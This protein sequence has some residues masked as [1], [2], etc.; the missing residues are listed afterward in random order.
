MAINRDTFKGEIDPRLDY[1]YN[2]DVRCPYC[3]ARIVKY[4]TTCPRCGI[5]KKQIFEASNVRAKEIMKAKTGEKIFMTRHRP[6]DVVFMR[7]VMLSLVCGL[8]GAH[9]FY[10]GRRIRG[11]IILFSTIFGL[12]S[13]ICVQIFVPDSVMQY[14][15]S[16]IILFPTDIFLVGA[17]ICWAYDFFGVVFG[18]F[19][20][21]IRLGEDVPAK[22]ANPVKSVNSKRF[23]EKYGKK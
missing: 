7:M 8:F 11:Y 19:K 15:R 5:H 12:I 22:T 1:L 9:C 3:H 6:D 16:T 2:K 23:A 18:F 4:T 20:Y 17:F 10:V 13:A 14:F 21:P